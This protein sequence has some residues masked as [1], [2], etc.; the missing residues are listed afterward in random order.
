MRVTG[1]NWNMFFIGPRVG[2]RAFPIYVFANGIHLMLGLLP[3]LR[4][5]I[6]KDIV[7]RIVNADILRIFAVNTPSAI[8]TNS[9]KEKSFFKDARTYLA[10]EWRCFISVFHNSWLLIWFKYL[11]SWTVFRS[12]TLALVTTTS[13]CFWSNNQNRL[14]TASLK[15]LWRPFVGSSN[16]DRRTFSVTSTCWLRTTWEYLRNWGPMRWMGLLSPFARTT[17]GNVQHRREKIV[18]V[19]KASG[20]SWLRSVSR[21]LMTDY[22]STLNEVVYVTVISTQLKSNCGLID[23][24]RRKPRRHHSKRVFPNS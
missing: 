5:G 10:N 14:M 2:R 11:E 24:Q 12:S 18:P 19:I 15:V 4:D 16:I 8:S 9:I 13:K 22:T 6:R 21:E 20:V 17:R 3:K 7:Q 23:L 1:E